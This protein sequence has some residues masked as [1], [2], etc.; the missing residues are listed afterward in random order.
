[1]EEMTSAQQGAETTV[2]QEAEK[3]FTQEEVNRVV[4]KRLERERKKY[5][6]SEELEQFRQW[7][8]SQQTQAEKWENLQKERNSFE[9]QFLESQKELTQMKREKYLL[10]Q[11]IA[12]ED[13]DYYAFKIAKAMQEN[14][15]FETVAQ[16]YLKEKKNYSIVNFGLNT[17]NQGKTLS[18]A[19]QINQK[20]R[21]V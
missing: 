17:T 20:L 4:E 6:S 14:D 5:Q 8:Q 11:G 19:D 10:A 9:A 12:A 2:Q 3:T 7:Q 15:D 16:N 21:G 18:L 13:V 1:M